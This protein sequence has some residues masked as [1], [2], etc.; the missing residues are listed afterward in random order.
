MLLRIADTYEYEVDIEV[1]ALVRL[2]EPLLIIL[3]GGVV[4]F[5]LF[6]VFL[7]L[8]ELIKKLGASAG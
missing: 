5:I 2:L 8:L 1:S 6:S 3:V 4:G 7:P